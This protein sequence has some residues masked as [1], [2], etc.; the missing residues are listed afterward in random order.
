MNASLV[1]AATVLHLTVVLPLT[2]LLGMAG[3]YQAQT[4]IN[5]LEK[6]LT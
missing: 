1:S 6:W 5:F 3:T 4:T 2:V